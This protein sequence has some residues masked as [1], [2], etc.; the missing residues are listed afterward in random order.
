MVLKQCC[1]SRSHHFTKLSLELSG[2]TTPNVKQRHGALAAQHAEH[3]HGAVL[4]T[5]GDVDAVRRRADEG[6][7]VLLARQDHDL[8]EGERHR[9]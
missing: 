6:D 4:V 2:T 9:G 8:V 5:H 3:A 7:L 1:V